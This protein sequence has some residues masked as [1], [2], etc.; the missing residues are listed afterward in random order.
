MIEKP[1][2]STG[3][4]PL[5]VEK[6]LIQWALRMGWTN[7]QIWFF[8]LKRVGLCLLGSS[9]AIVG[10]Y[11]HFFDWKISLGLFVFMLLLWYEKYRQFHA[12]Y[13]RFSFI[14]QVSFSKFMRMLIP[15]LLNRDAKRGLYETFGLI[16]QRVED[17]NL[18]QELYRLMNEMNE[19][20]HEIT[21]FL[22]FAKRCSETDDA[23]NFMT[24]L[25]YYQQSADD[26]RILQELGQL[27]NDEVFRGVDDIIRLKI[28]RM[29]FLPMIL[30]MSFAI[31]LL[32]IFGAMV[33]YMIQQI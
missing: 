17:P 28:R 23:I 31:P 33:F 22:A 18:A 19:F 8:Q 29:Q 15:Y 27:A 6:Q 26:P 13:R 3:N 9:L 21:P 32:G 2:K 25:F 16:A 30:T 24:T 7:K 11:M 10:W 12:H 20:P 4:L 1:T 5:F 14:Q